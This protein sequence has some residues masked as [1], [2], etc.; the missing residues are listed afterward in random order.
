MKALQK[1]LNHSQTLEAFLCL[2]SAEVVVELIE[3]HLKVTINMFK[4]ILWLGLR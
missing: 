3:E 4:L 1:L 2:Q